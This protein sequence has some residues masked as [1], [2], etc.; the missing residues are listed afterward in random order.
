MALA[1]AFLWAISSLLSILPA[2]HL[3]SF[4]YSR[5][6]IGCTAIMLS[7]IAIFN[8]GWATIHF[9]DILPMVLSGLV[10]IFIGD[11]ALLLVLI[12]W[13]P[14]KLDYFFHAMPYFLLS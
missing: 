13:G 11:T 12:E 3:G 4:S 6:R 8:N 10:G 2:R 1:A 9:N 5:W 7:S 14:V